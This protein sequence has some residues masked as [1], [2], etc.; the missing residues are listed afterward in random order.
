MPLR[1]EGSHAVQ[2]VPS[3]GA[4]RR[5]IAPAL[6][7]RNVSG[8]A[9][10]PLSSDVLTSVPAIVRNVV[11]QGDRDSIGCGNWVESELN[12]EQ[13]TNEFNAFTLCPLKAR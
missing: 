4:P 2:A 1:M 8:A 12:A 11:A 13:I 6:K 10:L 5:Y 7:R 9:R 3:V